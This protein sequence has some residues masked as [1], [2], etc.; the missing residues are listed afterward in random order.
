MESL[1]HSEL[2][3]NGKHE[4]EPQNGIQDMVKEV[5]EGKVKSGVSKYDFFKVKITSGS[6][7]S[8]SLLSRFMISRIFTSVGVNS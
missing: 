1:Q 6:A 8:Y 4:G 3:V 5:Y 2:E 7:D